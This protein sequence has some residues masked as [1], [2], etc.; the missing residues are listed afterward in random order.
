MRKAIWLA[1]GLA[2]AAETSAQAQ[3]NLAGVA[4]PTA[5]ARRGFFGFEPSLFGTQP[6]NPTPIA[7]P[8]RTIRNGFKLMDLIPRFGSPIGKPVYAKTTIPSYSP[9][10]SQD[11]LKAFGYIGPKPIGQ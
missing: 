2:L 6:Q 11:Y 1:L 5:P 8:N 7:V 10:M 3:S 9:L 4:A